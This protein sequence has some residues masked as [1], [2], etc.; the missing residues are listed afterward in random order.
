MRHRCFH[1][2]PT[3]ELIERRG[4]V[5]SAIALAAL[6]ASATAGGAIA[7]GAI[8]AHASGEAADKQTAAAN[9]AADLQDAA[10]KRA[11]A[12]QRQ[13]AE[14]AYQQGEV[15][16]QANYDQWAAKRRNIGSIS[17]MLGL[18]GG[19]DIPAYVPS[20]DPR[21]LD[22]GAPVSVGSGQTPAAAANSG[23]QLP[24]SVGSMI[25]GAPVQR[26]AL[27]ANAPAPT[28][29]PLAFEASMIDPARMGGNTGIT[30]GMGRPIL[31]P[32]GTYRLPPPMS[33]AGYLGA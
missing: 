19:G 10:N 26:P 14:Q 30:G 27:P 22:G 13:Q 16:R 5:A 12:F 32:D 2:L 6:A 9:H 21:Y 24:P 31:Q 33:I 3:G 28:S 25:N 17:Q 15:D 1:R 11:E 20:V 29:A 8:G 4:V 7:S 23:P 18:G